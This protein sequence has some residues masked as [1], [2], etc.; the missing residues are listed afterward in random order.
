MSMDEQLD[1]LRMQGNHSQAQ[2]QAEAST[3]PLCKQGQE[4]AGWGADAWTGAPALFPI[5]HLS[6]TH[7]KKTYRGMTEPVEAIVTPVANP[8]FV[9][10]TEVFPTMATCENFRNTHFAGAIPPQGTNGIYGDPLQDVFSTYFQHPVDKALSVTSAS[11][12]VVDLTLPSDP[13]T[14]Q[15]SF[16]FDKYFLRALNAF[17][18]SSNSSDPSAWYMQYHQF[19]DSF[20]SKYGHSAVVQASLGGMVEVHSSWT[21]WLSQEYSGPLDLATL[22]QNAQ[23]DWTTATGLGGHTGTPDPVYANNTTIDPIACIGGDP[24]KCS[25]G[26]LSPDGGAWATSVAVAPRLLRYQ[27]L[28]ISELLDDLDADVKLV[29]QTH[30]FVHLFLDFV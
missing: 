19:F 7:P 13:I 17:P 30:N 18:P 27:L 28:P 14:H 6:Y 8:V 5:A 25:K 4:C 10:D 1:Y 23:I 12:A 11:Y 29:R 24:S 21:T 9:M 16:T 2:L 20:F 22:Q 26:G 3:N 15:Y